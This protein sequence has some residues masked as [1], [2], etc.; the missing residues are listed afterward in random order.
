MED[1]GKKSW[2]GCLSY[3]GYGRWGSS[4]VVA[5]HLDAYNECHSH[6]YPYG[7]EAVES[8]PKLGVNTGAFY[9]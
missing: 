8:A 6:D 5:C 9:V 3:V 1:M 2:L 7:H 4:G